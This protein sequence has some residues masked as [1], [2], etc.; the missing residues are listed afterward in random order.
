MTQFMVYGV[1]ILVASIGA[2][3]F[4]RQRR[5]AYAVV[6]REKQERLRGW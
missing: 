3:V 1:V 2:A 5:P 6:R 4:V